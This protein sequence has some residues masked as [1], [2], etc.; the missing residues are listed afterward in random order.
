MRSQFSTTLALIAGLVL[1]SVNSF[2][3]EQTTLVLQ[4]GIMGTDGASLKPFPTEHSV[5][6]AA[7]IYNA[8]N[9][10]PDSYGVKKVGVKYDG[11]IVGLECEQPGSGIHTQTASC[12]IMNLAILP[13]PQRGFAAS[14]NES[15]V[16]A[17]KISKIIYETL[18]TTPDFSRIGSVIKKVG[19]LTCTLA[20]APEAIPSCKIIDIALGSMSVDEYDEEQQL[21]IRDLAREVGL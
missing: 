12:K 3:E 8:L 13:M 16:F 15:T 17:P 10:K 5:T 20:V 4:M 9:V 6:D 7:A 2:A 14:S 1:L 11:D 18:N 19:N 21:A